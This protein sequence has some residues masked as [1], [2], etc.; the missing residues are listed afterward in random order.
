MKQIISTKEAPEA[1]G[2]YS[3]AVTAG[4]LLFVSGQIALEPQTGTL[5]NENIAAETRQVLENLG[6]ILKAAGMDYYDVVQATVY[7]TSLDDF[8]EM[9]SAYAETFKSNPPSRATVE[10]SRLPKGARV[11]ISFVAAKE[12]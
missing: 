4:S 2:P 9:N 12:K 6:A 11:E 8:S 5:K 10:V 3:Q 7:L 1:I